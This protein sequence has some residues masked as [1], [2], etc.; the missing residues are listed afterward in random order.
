M[1]L[2]KF[3]LLQEAPC[4]YIKE[5][6]TSRFLLCTTTTGR[7]IHVSFPWPDNLC[8]YIFY[9]KLWAFFQ[10]FYLPMLQEWCL[11]NTQEPLNSRKSNVRF[12]VAY[13]G[14]K[15]HKYRT[16]TGDAKIAWDVFCDRLTNGVNWPS[17]QLQPIEVHEQWKTSQLI[18]PVFDLDGAEALASKNRRERAA[19]CDD[20][21]LSLHNALRD[22]VRKS[23]LVRSVVWTACSDTKLSLHVHFPWWVIKREELLPITR[24]V[25]VRM[26]GHGDFVDAQVAETCSLRMPLCD[27]LDPDRVVWC[28]RP[29][30]PF[31]DVDG[32]N[33]VYD[34]QCNAMPSSPVYLKLTDQGGRCLRTLV[35]ASVVAAFQGTVEKNAWGSPFIE[36]QAAQRREAAMVHRND[37]PE[38]PLLRMEWNDDDVHWDWRE[39][40]EHLDDLCFQRSAGDEQVEEAIDYLN[41]RAVI[42]ASGNTSVLLKVRDP[43]TGAVK[44]EPKTRADFVQTLAKPLVTIAS[45][46]DENNKRKA[47]QQAFSLFWLQHNRRNIV[48]KQVFVPRRYADHAGSTYIANCLNSWRGWRFWRL[49]PNMVYQDVDYSQLNAQQI[50]E[51]CESVR[52]MLAHIYYNLANGD[53]RFAQFYINWLANI[54][55]RPDDPP[56]KCIY[57]QGPEGEGKS[58]LAEALISQALGREHCSIVHNV[59]DLLGNHNTVLEG[60]I[61]L[62]LEEAT[63]GGDKKLAQEL[64]SIIT[65]DMVNINPKHQHLR[66]VNNRVN[67]LAHSNQKHLVHVNASAR[68]YAFC[69][70]AERAA[71]MHGQ[72]LS[73]YLAPLIAAQR[74]VIPFALFLHKKDLSDWLRERHN[75]RLHTELAQR[76]KLHSVPKLVRWW[77]DCLVKGRWNVTWDNVTRS[78]VVLSQQFGG[79]IRWENLLECCKRE[80][81]RSDKYLKEFDFR[82]EMR[83]LVHG[84]PTQE[85]LK[86]VGWID[87]G[88][89]ND[90]LA[91]K[92]FK[93]E[94]MQR[95]RA[96]RDLD[97][98][99][100]QLFEQGKHPLHENYDDSKWYIPPQSVCKLRVEREYAINFAVLA[101]G[102]FT[103][104]PRVGASA[105]PVL[106][107][108][109]DLFDGNEPGFDAEL[110]AEDMIDEEVD[111]SDHHSQDS[112]ST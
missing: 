64:Q 32:L 7:R 25:K 73:D 74:D 67:I 28:G 12:D 47:Q 65:T 63:F 110:Q 93:G 75:I 39:V 20:V 89:W 8:A 102:E 10:L 70:T 3:V 33:N 72:A 105:F 71:K 2:R 87:D 6:C 79:P 99:D 17:P 56:R 22:V 15:A 90:A 34:A 98:A 92:E 11:Q 78:I 54:V 48:N 66:T 5:V 81:G 112:D 68:R 52:V 26:A 31:T 85:E 58:V 109:E 69:K 42:D 9:D 53:R 100:K 37:Q 19:F 96:V 50:F 101:N 88:G 1:P 24:Y 104:R 29:L 51:R 103:R 62:C 35:R 60:C 106:A 14:G 76:Q 86:A 80:I 13:D 111:D 43:Q 57:L 36:W 21:L 40:Q 27:K 107:R 18:H 59:N 82:D 45:D 46:A 4:S 95:M 83:K 38:R 30:L 91:D 61:F 108:W 94:C 84:W 55:Q 16:W 77:I 44:L 23:D 97:P 49:A 41:C